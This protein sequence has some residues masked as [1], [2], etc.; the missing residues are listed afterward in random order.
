MSAPLDK[1]AGHRSP[2]F[3]NGIQI[4]EKRLCIGTEVLW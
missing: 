1:K 4:E 2:L 3:Y